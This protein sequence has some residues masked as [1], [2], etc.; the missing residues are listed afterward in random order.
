MLEFVMNHVI[1]SCYQ[2]SS[3]AN[4]MAEETNMADNNMFLC[5]FCIKYQLDSTDINISLM[6]QFIHNCRSVDI[7][8]IMQL[9]LYTFRSV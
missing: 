6:V 5:V 3:R 9:K 1:I 7:M 2:A 8:A 4:K